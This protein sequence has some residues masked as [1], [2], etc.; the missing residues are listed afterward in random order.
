MPHST[1]CLLVSLYFP[2]IL[3]ESIR[4]FSFVAW[5]LSLSPHPRISH[6][7]E[8]GS[9]SE[10]VSS[11]LCGSFSGIWPLVWG[12]QQLSNDF[13]QMYSPFVILSVF[14]CFSQQECQA[15][16]VTCLAIG[17]FPSSWF[18]SFKRYVLFRVSE[19]EWFNKRCM[20]FNKSHK[21][22]GKICL[23]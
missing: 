22:I 2:Y 4:M 9:C 18:W 1:S 10:K 14:S 8:D 6:R 17:K 19:S 15:A 16:K 20:S 11:P 3:W 7:S 21:K 5:F 23:L 13:K 12:P